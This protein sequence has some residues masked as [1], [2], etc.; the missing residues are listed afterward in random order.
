[1]RPIGVNVDASGT[2]F[3]A[4]VRCVQTNGGERTRFSA[5]FTIR[6]FLYDEEQ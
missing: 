4:L 1:M 6:C 5:A 2:I 3:L